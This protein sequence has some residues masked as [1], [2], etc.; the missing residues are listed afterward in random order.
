M[1]SRNDEDAMTIED[2]RVGLGSSGDTVDREV[3]AAKI[4]AARQLEMGG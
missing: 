2:E 4:D 3:P 1:E